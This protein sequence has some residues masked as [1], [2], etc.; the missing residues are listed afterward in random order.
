[1]QGGSKLATSITAGGWR[2][3]AIA[4]AA[5][6]GIGLAKFAVVGLLLHLQTPGMYLRLQDSILTGV[7]AAI[8]VWAALI[9]ASER[10]KALLEKVETIAMLNHELRNALEVILANEYLSESSKGAAILESVQRIDR[11]LDQIVGKSRRR[12]Q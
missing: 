12:S 11:T 10:R 5:A 9:V 4:I 7:L 8:A 6:V 2:L 1:M 3:V